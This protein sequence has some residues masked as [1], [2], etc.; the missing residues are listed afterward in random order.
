M[1]KRQSKTDSLLFRIGAIFFIFMFV[2]LVL[3]GISTYLNQT[4]IYQSQNRERLQQIADHLASLIERNDR[5]FSDYQGYFLEHADEMVIPRDF[6]DHRPAQHGLR[7]VG[8]PGRD[9]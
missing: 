7:K 9:E 6:S 8:R 3:S 1:S 2:M 5:N 4:A